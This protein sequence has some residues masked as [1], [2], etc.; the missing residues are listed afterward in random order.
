MRRREFLVDLTR[1]AALA[2]AVPN[3]WRVVRYPR[4]AD[5]PFSLGIA[6]GD[7]TP[8]GAVL[9]TRIAPK[10]LEPLGGMDS[11]KVMVAW[12]VATDERFNSI[13][14]EGRATGFP[15]LGYAIHAEVMGLEPDRWYF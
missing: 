15:E 10:P 2:A 4:F 8:G 13:V 11:L 12:E 14:K 1:L 6:S 5:D 3:D 9:W 7:P